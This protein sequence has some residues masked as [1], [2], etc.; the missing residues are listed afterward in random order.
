MSSGETTTAAPRLRASSM[1]SGEGLAPLEITSSAAPSSIASRCASARLPTTTTSPSEMPLEVPRPSSAPRRVPRARL[2]SPSHELAL[3]HVDDGADPGRRLRSV[4]VWR[5]SRMYRR[6][7]VRS[8]TTPTSA[9]CS[10]TIGTSSRSARAIAMPAAR[11]GSC[12]PVDREARLHH[13][14]GA[15]HHVGE[16]VAAPER[17]C[18]RAPTASGR[19]SS[20]RRTGMYSL[21]GSR[22]PFSSA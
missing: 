17:R 6:A 11:I 9:P 12:W 22:R 4:E 3:E 10:S 13:V 14:A 20:P 16:E 5:D 7:S 1:T 21:L 19:C 18:A 15:Q 8:V 2:S